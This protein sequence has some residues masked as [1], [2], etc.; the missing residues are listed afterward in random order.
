CCPITSEASWTITDALGN[1]YSGGHRHCHQEPCT[2]SHGQP[3]RVLR[4]C[5]H[6]EP[7]GRVF[8]QLF[9]DKIPKTAENFRALSTGEKGFGYN[10]S[11]FHR[12]IPGFMCQ[13]GDFTCHNGTGGN[14][15]RERPSHIV[16]YCFIVSA[17]FK[18]KQGSETKD[19][20]PSTRPK[21]QP[22]PAWP[23]PSS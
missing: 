19:R 4:Y 16:L 1:S 7:L 3:H 14:E 17:C 9:A 12:I 20:Q 10:D 23:K 5:C 21:T 22:E 11:Y 6:G 18:K 15:E 13:G 8:F 2:I